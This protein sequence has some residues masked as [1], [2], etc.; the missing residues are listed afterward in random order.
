M[1]SQGFVK[2]VDSMFEHVQEPGEPGE[3]LRMLPDQIDSVLKR[4]VC[5]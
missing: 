5:S 1:R 2:V 4:S 3:Y